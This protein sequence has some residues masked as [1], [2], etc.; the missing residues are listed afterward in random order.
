MT[1][2]F[3]TS[4]MFLCSTQVLAAGDKC[5]DIKKHDLYIYAEQKLGKS[6]GCQT[7]SQTSD[8][9][10]FGTTTVNFKNGKL[11]AETMPPETS[12]ITLEADFKDEKE[13]LAKLKE[14][15]KNAGLKINWE[16]PE[17]EKNGTSETKTFWDPSEGLNGRGFL[18]YKN[19]KLV[20]IG[21][22]MA[23]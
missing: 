12:V 23:L 5:A 18:T 14:A 20:S 4:L 2:M 21:L 3:L 1:K 11:T 9:Q 6:T 8:G 15:T 22:G 17:T 13:A 16:K 19:K 7:Q 10:T